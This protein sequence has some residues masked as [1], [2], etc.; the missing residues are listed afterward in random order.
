MYYANLNSVSG[1]KYLA[2]L[3]LNYG[4]YFETLITK[5]SFTH[6]NHQSER[7]AK[8][9]VTSQSSCVF[10]AFCGIVWISYLRKEA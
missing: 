1:C 4:G 2:P 6:T 8:K 5:R 10:S 9:F 3:G 7:I